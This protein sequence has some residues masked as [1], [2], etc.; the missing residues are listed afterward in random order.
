MA[1]M[2]AFTMAALLFVYTRTSIRAAKISAQRHR[3]AGGSHIDWG[4]EDRNR[5]GQLDEVDQKTVLKE[6]I[7]GTEKPEQPADTTSKP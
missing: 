6:A 7:L 1:P 2:V 4:R 3:E 5:R